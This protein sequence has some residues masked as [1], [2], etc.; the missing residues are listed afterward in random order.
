MFTQTTEYA[1]RAMALLAYSDE[2]DHLTS[3]QE[4]ADRARVPGNYLAKVLQQLAAANLITG[5]RGV[6]GGYRLARPAS[7]IRLIEIVRSVSTLERIKTCPLDLANHGTNLCPLHRTID[8]AAQAAIAVLDGVTLEDL[9]KGGDVK[10]LC[11]EAM[12]TKYTVS[13]KP[14]G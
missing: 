2:S 6:G 4:L 12:T 13:A 11:D 10:P 8:R 9:V 1:L 5:R 3:T 7:A 14:V